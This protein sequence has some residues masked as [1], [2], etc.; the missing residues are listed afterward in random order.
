MGTFGRLP[1]PSSMGMTAIVPPSCAERHKALAM[2]AEG[3]PLRYEGIIGP[4]GF[5][6]NG[7]VTGPLRLWRIRDGV[8]TTIGEMRADEVGAIE[9][10][11]GS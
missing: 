9:A 3:K 2:I 1:W 4:V 11:R 6:R 8:F 7:N 5:D 10:G